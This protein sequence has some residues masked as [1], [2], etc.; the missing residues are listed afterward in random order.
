E[1]LPALDALARLYEAQSRPADLLEILEQRLGLALKNN[2]AAQTTR[3][4][5]QIAAIDDGFGR[6]DQALE[7]YR[8]VLD[9]E[10]RNSA[11]RAGVEKYLEDPDL[12]LRAA[13]VL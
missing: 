10:P 12:R 1:D 3:L 7:R 6:R 9:V 13:E 4:R 2:E 11:A 5:L 8:E